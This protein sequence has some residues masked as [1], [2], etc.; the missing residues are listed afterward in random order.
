MWPRWHLTGLV[1]LQ[2]PLAAASVGAKTQSLNQI[3]R[4]RLAVATISAADSMKS[5]G[6]AKPPST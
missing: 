2:K 3:E 1:V 5:G 4:Q 6:S